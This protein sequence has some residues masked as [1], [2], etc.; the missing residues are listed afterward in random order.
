MKARKIIFK[1]FSEARSDEMPDYR[2]MMSFVMG[3]T[4]EGPGKGMPTSEMMRSVE[5]RAKIKDAEREFILMS[6]DDW[7]YLRK[8]IDATRW[9]IMHQ[10]IV[11]FIVAV[12]E[13]PKVDVKEDEPDS[14]AETAPAS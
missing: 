12:R 14:P 4:L 8:K 1:A 5:L 6:E 11:D 10:E 7:N 2:A 13:A 9:G 3:T